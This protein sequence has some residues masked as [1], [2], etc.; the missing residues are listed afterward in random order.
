VF[1]RDRTY[2]LRPIAAAGGPAVLALG[3]ARWWVFGLAG[4]L[5]LVSVVLPFAALLGN[6][7]PASIR[8]ALA[9]AGDSLL[10][11]L[12]YAAAGATLLAVLGFL[13]GYLIH[14]RALRFWRSVDSIAVFLFALPSTV[15][16]IGLVAIWNHPATGFIYGTP[17][18]LLFGYLAQ[19]AALTSRISVSALAQIPRALEEAAEVAGASWLRRMRSIVTPLAWRG[20]AGGWMV[21][22][23]FCLRDTGI[24]MMV[25]PPGHDTLPVRIFTL[26]ANGSTELI[27][28]L[29]LLMCA[30]SLAPL[31]VG[32][33]LLLWTRPT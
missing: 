5:C 11:S 12:W 15:I 29:C 33:A 18:I 23:I 28:A 24:S 32:G 19:Y 1:L 9:R 26:M 22:Y 13:L 17:L 25:Y 21:A 6:V 31:L 16:G 3:K 7:S 20:I 2:I 14:N 4:M 8:E 27:A 10:R 30:A